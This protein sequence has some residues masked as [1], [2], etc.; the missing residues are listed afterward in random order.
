MYHE[1]RKRGTSDSPA[2]RARK[3][4]TAPRLR[5]AAHSPIAHQPPSHDSDQLEL[6][7]WP[8]EQVAL[9]DIAADRLELM[10]FVRGL[11]AFGDG[12]KP[13]TL[14]K[15]DDGLA[16]AGTDPVDMAVGDIAA[17]DLQFAEGKLP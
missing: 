11:H 6:G 9:A 12:L 17:V 3:K 4:S 13:K 16:Q 10:A 5:F 8:G 1:L 2:L 7:H 15:L 14:A